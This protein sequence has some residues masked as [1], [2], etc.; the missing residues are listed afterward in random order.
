MVLLMKEN[1]E[2]TILRAEEVYKIF[3]YQDKTIE[4]LRNLSI[5][6]MQGKSY[7]ITGVS[8]IGKSTFMHI[9]AGLDQPT[10][11]MISINNHIITTFSEYERTQFLTQSVGLLF[12]NPYLIRELSVEENVM[13]PGII[14]QMP[15]KYCRDHAHD[16]LTRVNIAEKWSS[17]VGT[18][19]GGQQQRVALARALFH[20][21]Q[22]LL[23][24]E[25]TGNLD[26]QTGYGIVSLLTKCQHEWNMGLIISTHD[27]YVAQAMEIRYQLRDGQLHKI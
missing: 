27:M 18:L 15:Y 2:K 19:S 3:T 12:Q 16:L 23:A 24:D 25:P 9:L 26:E 7:A 1:M 20:K 8:G 5:T 4:V 11:G 22:F 17:A 21:P 14:A 13:L 6:F 10:Y